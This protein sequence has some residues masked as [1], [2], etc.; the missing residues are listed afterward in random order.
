VGTT[1]LFYGRI[2][3][4]ARRSIVHARTSGEI[5]MKETNTPAI[6]FC[7]CDVRD[8]SRGF[9]YKGVTLA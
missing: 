3:A 7:F 5:C 2:P 8:H 9:L 4:G 6:A 1:A